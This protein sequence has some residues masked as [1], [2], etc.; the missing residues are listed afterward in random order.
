MGE[1]VDNMLLGYG[2][3]MCVYLPMIG[4]T[5]VDKNTPVTCQSVDATSM[6]ATKASLE[7][8]VEEGRVC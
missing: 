5:M 1:R 7:E 3:Y 4:M 2:M 8:R 6:D